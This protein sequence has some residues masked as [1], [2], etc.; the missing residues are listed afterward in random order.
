MDISRRN[1]MTNL[2]VVIFDLAGE[3]FD[4]LILTLAGDASF[5]ILSNRIMLAH[6][7]L[8]LIQLLVSSAERSLSKSSPV[9]MLYYII[10]RKRPREWMKK[11]IAKNLDCA[12]MSNNHT[13]SLLYI[14]Y[15]QSMLVLLIFW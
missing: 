8:T 12:L 3:N 14:E 1:P 15:E 2:N 9:V 11:L 10:V 4:V 6:A 5:D 13:E 7:H